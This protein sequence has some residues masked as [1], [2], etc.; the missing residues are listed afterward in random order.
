M[1]TIQKNIPLRELVTMRVGGLARFFSCVKDIEELSQSIQFAKKEN[2]P[3]FILG[4]GSN[5]IV[6]DK[7]VPGLVIKTA[8]RG[9]SFFDEANGKTLV[10]AAAGENWDR[11]VQKSVAK[12]LWG[13]ENLSAIPGTVGAAPVQ[14]V[15]AYGVE[16]KDTI[17]SVHVFD[18]HTVKERTLSRAE[19][20]FSYRDSIFKKP[21]GKSLVITKVNFMLKRDGKPQAAYKDIDVS[22]KEK[23]LKDPTIEDMRNIILRIRRNKLPSVKK[24]GTVGSFFKNP[25]LSREK[26]EALAYLY[27]GLPQYPESSGHVKIPLAW[28][29]DRVCGRRGMGRNG[30]SL[31]DTQPLALVH[32]GGSNAA[33]ILEFANEIARDIKRHTGID[34]EFEVSL[35]G[36]F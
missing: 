13:V 3:V 35:V 8:I 2:L 10:S 15:G 4:E 34:A 30:L 29:I 9:I 24:V 11:F 18:M 14:N 6:G 20:G 1:H 31:H 12:K 36:E 5:I 32:H 17:H 28:I 19:C 25:I 33:E 22:L 23:K 16:V 7:G 27:P 26:Y 21:E